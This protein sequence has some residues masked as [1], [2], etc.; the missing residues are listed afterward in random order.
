MYGVRSCR[1]LDGRISRNENTLIS[2]AAAAAVNCRKSPKAYAN[3]KNP[4]IKTFRSSNR[5]FR[6]RRISCD[7]GPEDLK[8]RFIRLTGRV[9]SV[10]C[11]PI[12]FSLYEMGARAR[13]HSCYG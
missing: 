5:I 4:V 3:D 12:P 8:C 11:R 9:N 6:Y 7:A 10:R 1:K 2:D 13:T